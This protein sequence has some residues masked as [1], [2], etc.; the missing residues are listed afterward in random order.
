MKHAWTDGQ[1]EALHHEAL[2]LLR[3][4]QYELAFDKLEL[5]AE[6]DTNVPG[7]VYDI[8]TFVFGQLGFL[9]EA[10]KISN[11]RLR[12]ESGDLSPNLWYYLLDTCS[13]AYHL[14]GTK[15]VW[16]RMVATE[17]L[18]PSD[19]MTLQVLN[20]AARW[21]DTLL[22][23]GAIQL[24]TDRGAKIGEHH[25]EA[26]IECYAGNQD[27]ENALRVLCI[28]V[29]S[30]LNTDEH[31]TRSLFQCL[32]NQPELADLAIQTLQELREEYFVPISA[33]NVVIEAL[34]ASG[35]LASALDVYRAIPSICSERANRSTFQLLLEQCDQPEVA[36]SL[37]ADNP[38]LV[39]DA[40]RAVFD[41]LIFD[42]ALAGN[43]D[44]ALKLAKVL[45]DAPLR[46]AS[47]EAEKCVTGGTT[48]WLSRQTVL[49]LVKRCFDAE[50]SR[51]WAVVDEARKRDMD[52]EEGIQKIV[53]AL[54]DTAS[55]M[56]TK[57][58]ELLEGGKT[59]S[60]PSAEKDE[61]TSQHMT[62]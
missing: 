22:A 27:I 9:D 14:E 8:F 60:A 59:E 57:V 21:K 23:T 31:T 3:D 33:V 5:I 45:Q 50:D 1:A 16:D 48:N 47:I 42:H 32:R 30:G 58:T 53:K 62:A 20:T 15:Y 35:S 2:G 51:V 49:M 40:N 13:R 11:Y 18:N 24:L 10:V 12:R 46:Q 6:Q 7:W 28:M 19:G 54:P 55:V 61:A 38:R 36:D 25:F 44:T 26:L 41:R 52:I 43:I 37:A 29:K 17:R 39:L 4:G 56:T 34:A